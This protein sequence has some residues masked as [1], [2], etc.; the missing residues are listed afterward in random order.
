MT[1]IDLPGFINVAID[2]AR[3]KIESE[4]RKM[5]LNVISKESCIILAVTPANTDITNSDALK[6]AREVDPQGNNDFLY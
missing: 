3:Y 2:D 5:T 1:L 4:V 6:I